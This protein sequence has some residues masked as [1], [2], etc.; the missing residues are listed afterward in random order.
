VQAAKQTKNEKEAIYEETLDRVFSV[1]HKPED[2]HNFLD[3]IG[4]NRGQALK[5]TERRL[6]HT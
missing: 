5:L 1:R 3:L 6:T 2:L 4:F